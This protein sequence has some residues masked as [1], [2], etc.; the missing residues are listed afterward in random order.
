VTTTAVQTIDQVTQPK[1]GLK[2][3]VDMNQRL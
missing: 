1:G 3:K 2:A